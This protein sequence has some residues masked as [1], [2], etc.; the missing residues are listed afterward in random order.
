MINFNIIL[1]PTT[2]FSIYSSFHVSEP[3]YCMHLSFLACVTRSVN[4]I[5]PNLNTPLTFQEDVF[6]CG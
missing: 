2:R 1:P 6:I 5:S 3:K 4:L